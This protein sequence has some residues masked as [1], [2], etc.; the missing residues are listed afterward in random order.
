MGFALAEAFY[1]KGADVQLV[2][3]PTHQ[4]TNLQWHKGY[5]CGKC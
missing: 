4:K 2:T 1:L 5:T 3:G